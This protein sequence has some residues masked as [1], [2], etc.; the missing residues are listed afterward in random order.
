MTTA[1]PPVAEYRCYK[2]FQG[3]ICGRFIF[4]SERPITIPQTHKCGK[5]KQ[6]VIFPRP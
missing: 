4:W 5:C 2:P 1:T 3:G 6:M